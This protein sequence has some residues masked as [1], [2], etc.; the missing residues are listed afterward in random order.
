[1]MNLH[2]TTET[3]NF[4]QNLTYII[5]SSIKAPRQS[6]L[7]YHRTAKAVLHSSRNYKSAIN[8]S[9]SQKAHMSRKAKHRAL[10][11]DWEKPIVAYYEQKR[12]FCPSILLR[13][14]KS[15][16]LTE[17]PNHIVARLPV[18]NRITAMAKRT[19]L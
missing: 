11:L 6:N 5:H 1:M 9:D 12:L 16:Y 4:G 2:N 19:Y 18:A 13:L 3:P 8:H 10:L 14:R 15:P 17:L 7:S